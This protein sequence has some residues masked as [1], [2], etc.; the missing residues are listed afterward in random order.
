MDK[1]SQYWKEYTEFLQK[2]NDLTNLSPIELQTKYEELIEEFKECQENENTKIEYELD[3]ELLIRNDI[4]LVLLNKDLCDNRFRN[5][6]E[7]KVVALDL[8]IKQFLICD[9]NK[10]DW[11]NSYS[12]KK[13]KPAP[14]KPS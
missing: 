8:E 13:N 14:N 11:W 12:I 7:A 6:F 1:N 4:Q 10:M 9:E 3:Y 2:T 5:E